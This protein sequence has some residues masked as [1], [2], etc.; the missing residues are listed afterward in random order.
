MTVY[1]C[2][3]DAPYPRETL[4]ALRTRLLR[5]GGYSAQAASPPPGVAE[6]MDDFLMEA[7]RLVYANY[8]YFRTERWFTWTLVE[9]ERFYDFADG[10]DEDAPCAAKLLNPEKI[11]WA[12][13]S[14]DDGSWTPLTRGINPQMYSQG[15]SPS[16]YPTR[17]EVR[18]CLELWPAPGAAAG[19][20]RILGNFGLLPF[21]A[22]TDYT[23]IDADTVFL[24]A[25]TNLKAHQGKRD[26]GNYHEQEMERV[27]TLVA[28]THNGRRYIPSDMPGWVAGLN[29]ISGPVGVR[30][31]D[32]GDIRLVE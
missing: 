4:L 3:C 18:Q 21:S 12:G 9:D 13:I 28:A 26:A 6:L 27:G 29:G 25:L 16:G 1:N 31:T 2:E 24:R 30:F 22:P 23:T 19:K 7:Q 14:L 15:A 10:D 17:F 32:G 11:K 8:A 20:L 5:R